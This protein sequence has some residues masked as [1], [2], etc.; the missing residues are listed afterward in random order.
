M[1]GEADRTFML[2]IDSYH[3]GIPTGRFHKLSN[4]Q[5]HHFDSLSQL[6]LQINNHLDQENFPQAFSRM[7][8]FQ[9]PSSLTASPLA[10]ACSKKGNAATFIIR[11]LFRQNA[12]WQGNITWV[13][14]NQEEYFRSVLELIHLLDNALSYKTT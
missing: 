7:R 5:V 13:E 1:K 12:S 4:P 6:L 3:N 10:Q 14:G 9:N 2:Y 11:I 8:G